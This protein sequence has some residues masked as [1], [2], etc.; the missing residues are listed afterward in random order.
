MDKLFQDIGFC[1]GM[2]FQAYG[3]NYYFWK[4]TKEFTEFK[5]EDKSS[6]NEIIKTFINHF[7]QLKRGNDKEVKKLI[8][9][10][11]ISIK[12][13]FRNLK[14]GFEDFTNHVQ[15][16]HDEFYSQK[17]ELVRTTSVNILESA[18]KKFHFTPLLSRFLIKDVTLEERTDIFLTE[19]MMMEVINPEKISTL[20]FDKFSSF[21][22][23]FSL[24]KEEIILEIIKT[25]MKK[26]EAE[27]TTIL[28]GIERQL[29]QTLINSINSLKPCK[30]TLLIKQLPGVNNQITMWE[31]LSEFV[32]NDEDLEL[33][34]VLSLGGNEVLATIALK[35]TNQIICVFSK[36]LITLMSSTTIDDFSTVF[37]D[38]STRDNLVYFSNSIRKAFIGYEHEN[39]VIVRK[40]INFF[41][42]SIPDIKSVVL[43]NSKE[44]AFLTRENQFRLALIES[45]AESTDASEVI[46]KPYSDILISTCKN[47]LILTSYS[48][49]FVFN[50]KLEPVLIETSSPRFVLFSKDLLTCVFNEESGDTYVKQV[51]YP[52]QLETKEQSSSS[53]SRISVQ[54]SRTLQLGRGILNDLL[55][56]KKFSMKN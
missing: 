26:F 10:F 41:N 22:T 44:V 35:E 4:V 39:Q 54:Y 16:L 8:S 12:S 46:M 53:A 32:L 38:G 20:F 25:N 48:E 1:S 29:K 42:P 5:L 49:V 33:K 45:K 43:I 3:A 14:I 13:Y 2:K 30:S 11:M 24:D 34:Q 36:E 27:E 7:K 23:G 55:I 19:A 15:S 31:V 9:Q 18:K 6:L 37:A 51:K 47:F 17:I 50:L 56:E 40:E 52:F 28:Y 21:I